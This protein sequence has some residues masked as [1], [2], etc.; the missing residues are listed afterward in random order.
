MKQHIIKHDKEFKYEIRKLKAWDW[1]NL[2]TELTQ[3]VSSTDNFKAHNI[4]AALHAMGETGIKIEGV[5]NTEVAK[6][7]EYVSSNTLTFFYETFRSVINNASEERRY[8]IFSIALSGVYL[9]NGVPAA[10][11]MMLPLS[12][13][14]VDLYIQS[15]MDMLELV[16]ES[17]IYNYKPILM[18]FFKKALNIK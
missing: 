5:K 2:L 1:A 15:P 16:K 9:D 13:D 8:K 10:G 3:C 18:R 4:I 12:L 11:G 17:L 14:D 7:L 6:V